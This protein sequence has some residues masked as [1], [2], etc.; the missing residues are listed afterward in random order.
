M[1]GRVDPLDCFAER[2]AEGE[3]EVAEV[4]DDNDKMVR[5]VCKEY[6][7]PMPEDLGMYEIFLE[8]T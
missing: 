4:E 8:L 5:E 7:P 3:G 2:G 6:D 1:P